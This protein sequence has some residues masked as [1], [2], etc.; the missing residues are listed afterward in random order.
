MRGGLFFKF[1]APLCR[2]PRTS[3]TAVARHSG[4][5][6]QPVF[7]EAVHDAGDI[8]VRHH[9]K[10]AQLTHLEP[11]T[12]TVERAHDIKARQGGGKLAAQPF[13]Q[14][15]LDGFVE[16]EQP[17]PDAQALFRQRP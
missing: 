13:A 6:D 5:Q 14:F 1:G 16:L 4:A 2:E 3:R 8:S 15:G 9:Q 11:V 17:Q 12:V 10:A 7:D